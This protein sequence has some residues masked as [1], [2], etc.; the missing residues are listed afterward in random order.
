MVTPATIQSQLT[1]LNLRFRWFGRA[2]SRELCKIISPGEILL[3][4]VHGYYNGGAGLLVATDKRVILLD[5]RP[6]YLNLEEMRY[7]SIRGVEYR[8]GF[9]QATI[10][11]NTGSKRLVF[12]SASDAQLKNIERVVNHHIELSGDTFAAFLKEEIYKPRRP[13]V[14]SP[15]WRPHNP[16]MLPGRFRPRRS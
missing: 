6:L 16:V 9:L 7:Q 15:A 5:K 8:P 12:R 1:R 13:Y 14:F 2:E 10:D 11:I 3:A 4:C